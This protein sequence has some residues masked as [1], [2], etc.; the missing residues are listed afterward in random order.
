[1]SRLR[2]RTL[3][4][5]IVALLCALAVPASSWAGGP[6]KWTKLASPNNGADT[7]GML[8]T[9]NRELHL[10][11]WKKGTKLNTNSYGTS[12][13]SLAGKLLATGTAVSNW[14]S[15]ATDPQ[16]VKYGSGLR[17]IFNGNTGTSGCYHDGEIFTAT[18]A[19]GSS[20][21]LVNGSMDQDVT[22][23][24]GI[25]ATA[26]LNG[27]PVV[28]FAAGHYFHVGVD[29]SCPASSADGMITMTGTPTNPATVTD[30]HN[31]SVWVAWF[32]SSTTGGYFVDQ[33]LP[34]QGTPKKALASA[35]TNSQNNQPLEPVALAA[36]VGGGEYMAYCVANS[37]QPCVH[38]DLW[39]VGSSKPMVVPGSSNTHNARVS[40]AAAPGGRV[41]VTW[42]TAVG[43]A[44]DKGVIHTVRTNTS[45]TA[46]GV[47]RTIKA[48]AHTG[49]LNDLQTQDSTGRLDVVV[50]DGLSTP[51]YPFDLFQTQI[52]P[53]LSLHA[54]PSS[55][56]HKK[57]TTVTFTVGDAGQP[58][59]G[60]KVS[61]VGKTATTS[62]A[63]QA[64]IK[65]SKGTAVG[66]H[67]CTASKPGYAA[68]LT[69]LTVT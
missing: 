65:F 36:R 3:V 66:K 34:S 8:R 53:G 25:A 20:W 69:T 37:S 21:S 10:V 4:V 24:G 22:G 60:A 47:I 59:V 51:P 33:I 57:A 18:S 40:L 15:L 48:P 27:T 7:V 56:S 43:G 32:Q 61:C 63:G 54:S 1:M 23:V 46:F 31:G 6:G 52:L 38:L 42:F 19:N 28:A 64:K 5:G 35:P 9:P 58:V 67:V 26:E 62:S 50:N 11:W 45:A 16:L 41:A 30:L 49:N 2:F 55:F 39:K 14:G 13:I 29:P 17:L 12:T 68:G 44:E